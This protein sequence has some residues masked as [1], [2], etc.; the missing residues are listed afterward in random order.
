MHDDILRLCVVLFVITSLSTTVV[1]KRNT[2]QG[3]VTCRAW[4]GASLSE[5]L[6][7]AER[8]CELFVSVN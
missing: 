7:R 3:N 5:L 1:V 8:E 4:F 2:V 6:L